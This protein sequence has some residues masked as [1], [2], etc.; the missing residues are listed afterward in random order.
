[1]HGT[2]PVKAGPAYHGAP[3]PI[4]NGAYPSSY[5][6]NQ[7]NAYDDGQWHGDVYNAP[8]VHDYSTNDISGAGGDKYPAGTYFS[9]ILTL[10]FSSQCS[11]EKT[12]SI[13]EKHQFFC[14][15]N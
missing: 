12:C 1:M 4:W 7:H 15:V 14:D 9:D 2:A 13:L 8:A 11:A 10:I 6:Y 3:A 5:A